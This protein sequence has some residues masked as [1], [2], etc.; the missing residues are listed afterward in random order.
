MK[1]L[2]RT[3]V[4]APLTEIKNPMDSER[5]EEMFGCIP[6]CSSCVVITVNLHGDIWQ[7][8]MKARPSVWLCEYTCISFT[9]FDQVLRL[10]DFFLYARRHLTELH[11]LVGGVSI[12]K[13]H[14]IPPCLIYHDDSTGVWLWTSMLKQESWPPC[15]L[16]NMG[17]VHD[18][19]SV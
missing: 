18:V 17:S 13:L 3:Q 16:L 1:R 4:T 6:G 12:T 11:T 19:I 8:H 15:H 5:H 2:L 9:I 10:D 7:D 14:T